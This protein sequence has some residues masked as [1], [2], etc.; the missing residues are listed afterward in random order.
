MRESVVMTVRRA[1]W[2]AVSGCAVAALGCLV[3]SGMI[4]ASAVFSVRASAETLEE[5]LASTYYSNPTI[6]AKRAEQRA[7]D[8]GV[9]IALSDIRPSV[10]FSADT[11]VS[12]NNLGLSSRSS[13]FSGVFPEG[14]T[15]PTGY[16]FTL[17]QNLFRGFRTINAAREA[18]ANVFAGIESLRSVEQEVLLDAVSS[19]IDVLRDQAIVRLGE[20][21]VKVL[22]SQLK[23]TKDRFEV[24]EV[25]R[26]DTAQSQARLSAANSDLS[27]ARSNLK[28]S[29]ASFE[30]VIGHPAGGLTLPKTIA[31][32][33]PATQSDA[34]SIA[35]EE[36]PTILNAVFLAEAADYAVRELRGELLPEV[37]FETEY[38]M[39]YETSRTTEE[40]ETTT[41][42]GRVNV[43]LYQSGSVAARVRQAKDT[44]RR[45][46]T[47]T[48]V[49]RNQNR[50]DVISAWS[51][52]VSVNAQIKSDQASVDANSIA[53][54]GVRDEE[55]VGQRTILDVLD[56]EQELLDSNVNLVTTRR[57][58]VL[59]EYTLLSAFGSLNS[60]VLDLP[61]Q[62]YDP[63]LHY[64]RA[65]FKFLGLRDDG[66][67]GW[68][69]WLRNTWISRDDR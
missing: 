32:Q 1:V 10:G 43:P 7:I 38:Q 62:H 27:L 46:Q 47:E 37:T 21:N 17:N 2:Y 63:L 28:T 5:A 60:Y 35:E 67:V 4:L 59:A 30:R 18:K 29:R 31:S 52:L 9:P 26:T 22:R 6:N 16:S 45:R 25:T 24:G 33:L 19:Y 23:A 42:M 41:Y 12:R 58:K 61:V 14:K 69:D 66:D 44:R 65:K 49:A 54:R 15:R 48:K 56:A 64:R 36:S 57:D 13:G 68:R 55:R 50:A 53:L 51:Q 11:G 20:N 34:L 8:E 40:A 3:F 39:R